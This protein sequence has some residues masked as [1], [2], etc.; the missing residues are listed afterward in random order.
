MTAQAEI[1]QIVRSINAAWTEGRPDDLGRFLAPDV[2]FVIP[3]A[4]AR[5]AGRDA[6]VQTYRDFLAQAVL[7]RF[8]ASDATVDVADATAVALCPYEIE[9]E[10]GGRRWRGDGHDLLVFTHTDGGWRVVWR[11]MLS[12]PEQEMGTG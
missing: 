3:D 2:V 10:I 12:K 7:H 8:V 5:A 9:Y 6:C 1:Q 11:T 4:G